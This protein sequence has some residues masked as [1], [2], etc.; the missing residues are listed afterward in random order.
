MSAGSGLYRATRVGAEAYAIR[1]AE[2]AKRFTLVRSELRDGINHVLKIIAWVM[3]P[4]VVLLVWSQMS[5]REPPRRQGGPPGVVA[6]IVAMVPE[7]LVLLT[8]VAFA[9]GAVR[10]GRRKVLVQE[11]PAV[12]GLARVDVVC[13]DKTGTLT[14]GRLVVE[15][16]RSWTSGTTRRGPGRAGRL[17]PQPQRHPGGGRRRPSLPARR[18]APDGLG[19][20]LLRPQVELGQLRGAGDL[21]SWGRRS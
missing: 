10:L 8:R 14:E 12:E 15:S 19:A 11:L 1:L 9:V 5:R 18:L 3:V 17:R 6:G 20:L 13:V 2:E 21:A 16:L 7:G 4:T